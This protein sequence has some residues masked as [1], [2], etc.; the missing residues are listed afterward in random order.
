MRRRCLV[1][2]PSISVTSRGKMNSDGPKPRKP[3]A[4][5]ALPGIGLHLNSLT[6]VSKDVLVSSEI[7]LLY[8]LY[9]NSSMFT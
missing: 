5:P 8:D 3:P 9:V 1:F 6:A 2:D 7:I 4:M